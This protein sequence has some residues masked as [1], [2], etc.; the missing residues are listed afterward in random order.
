MPY[1][2][3][4]VRMIIPDEKGRVLI[5]KRDEG[6]HS[7]GEWCLPGGKVDYGLTVEEAAVKELREETSLICTS[8]RFLFYQDSL[9]QDP[10]DMHGINLYFECTAEGAIALNEE[11]RTFAWIGPEELPEYEMAFRNDEGLLRYW[12]EKGE[13]AVGHKKRS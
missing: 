7:G 1:P 13:S 5:L 10:E 12:S 6:S 11:S 4:I 2:I 8:T 9:P 3:P